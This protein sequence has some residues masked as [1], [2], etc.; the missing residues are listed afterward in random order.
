MGHLY[1]GYVTNNQMAS[2][3]LRQHGISSQVVR[4]FTD[5]Q[6]CFELLYHRDDDD[7]DDDDDEDD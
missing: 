4:I 3:F 5:N 6:Q 2:F 1:H 7:D